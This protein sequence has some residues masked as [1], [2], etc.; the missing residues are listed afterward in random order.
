LPELAAIGPAERSPYRVEVL[1]SDAGELVPPG[2][3]E[4]TTIAK[5]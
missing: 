1:V 3:A 2:V 5:I 4:T